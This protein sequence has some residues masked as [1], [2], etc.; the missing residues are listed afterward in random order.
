MQITRCVQVAR[1]HVCDV[2]MGCMC[3]M[4]AMYVCD[5]RVPCMHACDVCMHICMRECERIWAHIRQGHGVYT[6]PTHVCTAQQPY[7]FGTHVCTP[8]P[9]HVCTPQQ[10]DYFGTRLEV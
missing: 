3:A 5:V 10:P 4:Y 2:C 1:A 6:K 9:T 8:Q 7:Y